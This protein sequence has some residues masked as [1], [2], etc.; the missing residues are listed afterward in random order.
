L[1]QVVEIG[2][3]VHVAISGSTITITPITDTKQTYVTGIG[4]LRQATLALRF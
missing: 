2:Q 3:S 1:S 4:E